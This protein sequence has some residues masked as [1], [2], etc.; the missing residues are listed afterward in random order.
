MRIAVLADT[1]GNLVALEA[2]LADLRTQAPDLIINLGDLFTGPF[3]PAGSAD[4]QIG[5]GCPT[6]AGNHERNLLEGDDTSKSVAFARPLLSST[7]MAW[8]SQLPVTL[9]LAS[10]DV[11]ACHGSPAGGDL[12]YLL[13]DVSSGRPVLAADDAIRS[14]LA[15]AGPASLVLCGH[16]HMQRVVQVGHVTVVN[17]GS[18]GMP[19]YTDDRPIP[20]AIET[21]SPHARY[22]VVTRK[23]GGAWSADLRSVA[24]DWDRAAQQARVNG[25]S[26]VARWT[27][28]GRV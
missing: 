27:L 7:H 6:L 4:V 22:A 24:Y 15:G 13:E 26:S 21:G 20:H 23:M 2:I 9:R 28:T 17:P 14:R 11:F 1:H 16:T 10:D 8:I 18:V 12:D 5:L 25:S 19:A 3:D